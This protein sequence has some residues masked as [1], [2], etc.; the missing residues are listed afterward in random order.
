VSQSPGSGTTVEAGSTVDVKV[1]A[2]TKMSTV[3]FVLGDSRAEAEQKLAD[4]GLDAEFQ[5]RASD[6]AKDTVIETDP[7]AGT[8]VP[9]G[10][11]VTVFVSTGP[12]QVP[13][14]VGLPQSEAES[15]LRRA[16]FDVDAEFDDSTPSEKGTVLAQDPE[17]LSEAPRGSTV[18]ITVSSY[19]EPSSSPPTPTDTATP[20]PTDTATETATKP[21]E[22]G[23]G[24]GPTNGAGPG[25]ARER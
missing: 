15:R 19:D 1:S 9:S 6:E 12:V 7:V 20:T 21:A 2:G 10:S 13:N 22:P 8:S 14:V 4:A 23:A 17:G 18:T 11:S 5:E 16:G 24:I 25:A 3:P